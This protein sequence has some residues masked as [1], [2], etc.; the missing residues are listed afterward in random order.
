MGPIGSLILKVLVQIFV[1]LILICS[2]AWRRLRIIRIRGRFVTTTINGLVFLVIVDQP[3]LLVVNG[4]RM[5][6]MDRWTLPIICTLVIIKN[7]V[8]SYLISADRKMYLCHCRIYLPSNFK[9][10][11]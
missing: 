9:I 2:R 10:H 7:S 3:D 8:Y 1:V 5:R 6:G 11:F 4:I